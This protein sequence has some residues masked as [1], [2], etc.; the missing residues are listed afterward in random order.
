MATQPKPVGLPLGW[1]LPQQPDV[2]AALSKLCRTTLVESSLTAVV[3]VA[4]AVAIALASILIWVYLPIAVSVVVQPVLFLLIGSRQ[5]GLENLV[6]HGAHS[7]FSRWKWLNDAVTDL[8]AGLLVFSA[9]KK[10]RAT[11]RPHHEHFRTRLDPDWVR[12]P[13]VGFDELDRR[14]WRGYVWGLL[15]RLPAYTL[16]WWRSIGTD[17]VTTAK[18]VLWQILVFVAPLTWYAGP[19]TALLL[20]LVYWLVTLAVVLPIV[21]FVAEAGEHR[22]G[23]AKNLL[24]ATFNNR[25]ILHRWIFHPHADGLHLVHHLMPGVSHVHIPR[26]HEILLEK[27]PIYRAAEAK[28]HRLR[29]LEEP[30]VMTIDPVAGVQPG[31]TGDR[32]RQ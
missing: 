20:W 12:S 21:R 30:R 16:G 29:V 5:R 24:T 9:A 13:Q 8:L 28:Q 32:A 26:V 22:Y 19:W 10:F 6:H 15:V 27:D 3:D 25:G 1:R 17:W 31:E 18:A 4:T 7:H 2:R 14:T 11:H 23:G